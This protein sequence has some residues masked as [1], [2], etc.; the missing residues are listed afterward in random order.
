MS[1]DTITIS[2]DSDPQINLDFGDIT[3]DLGNQAAAQPIYSSNLEYTYDTISLPQISTLTLPDITTMAGSSSFYNPI[4][5]N[6]GFITSSWNQPNVHINSN[7]MSLPNDADIKIGDKSLKTFM[8]KVEEKLAIL[9][10]NEE[11]EKKWEQLR[12]LRRQYQELEKDILE[13][14]KIMRILK[15]E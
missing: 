11:L 12:D 6:N 3:I 1:S 13:K 8:E 15:E 10:P 2:A 9:R 14:E 4:S 7:G 5:G